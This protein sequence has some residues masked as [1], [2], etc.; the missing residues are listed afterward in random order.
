MIPSN[1]A[2]VTER[3]NVL[4]HLLD[5][6]LEFHAENSSYGTH[7]FHAFAAKFPPQLPALFIRNLTE[8][9]EI[10]LDP[11]MGSGTAVVEAV[12]AGR[13][14]M[15]FDIDPLAVKLCRVK[16][17]PIQDY[18]LLERISANV[19]ASALDILGS[20]YLDEA[21]ANRLDP[22]TKSFID[23]WFLQR[24][25]HELMSLLL[26]IDLVVNTITDQDLRKS[27]REFLEIVFS[28]IIVTKSGGV[29]K[30]RDLAHSRPHID[31]DKVPRNAVEQFRS[32]YKSSIK[33]MK[34]LASEPFPRPTLRQADARNL[35][36]LVEDSSIRLVITSPPYANAID[37]VRAHKFSLVWL[38]L[39]IEELS[40][41]RSTYIGSERTQL[42]FKLELFPKDVE[43]VIAEVASRDLKRSKVLIRYFT[44]MRHVLNEINR[45]LMPDSTAVIVIGSSTMRGFR[46]ET[47]RCLATIA[48]ALSPPLVVAGI[49]H[50]RLDR[51]KRM[52]PAR[53]GKC[54]GSAIE[55]RMHEE[56]IIG[57]YK[58]DLSQ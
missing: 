36:D 52:M 5:G 25:Q 15:G 2:I 19:V 45:V 13:N 14:S 20:T 18:D 17:N 8:P 47:A 3:L 35:V 7:N 27:I 54:N 26:S 21:I 38:G 40:L 10:V 16:T 24:T 11:M 48:E 23:Y 44:D 41:K 4:R 43:T 51:D 12:L 28:S 33:G 1:S 56:D 57:L 46:V 6:N 42:D 22:K 37:Y 29:S 31:K 50:R 9:G 53:N 32:R 34:T 58:P 55:Q 30:A 49:G 39:S